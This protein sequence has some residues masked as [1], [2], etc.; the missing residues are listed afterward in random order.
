MENKNN[1]I[2]PDQVSGNSVINLIKNLLKIKKARGTWSNSF[3]TIEIL[4]IIEDLVENNSTIE[5]DKFVKSL[6]L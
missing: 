1:Q 6:N 2:P 5:Y 4:S 3:F